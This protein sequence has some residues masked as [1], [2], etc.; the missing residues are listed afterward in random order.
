MIT[1]PRAPRVVSGDRITSTQLAGLADAFNARL[2]S[3]LGDGHWRI[4]FY[5][6]SLFRQIR[7]PDASGFLWAPNAEFFEIY[8]ML[9]ETV[10]NWPVTGPGDPEGI[11]VS[12][13][14]GGYV[15]GNDTAGFFDEPGRLNIPLTIGGH[16]PTTDAEW[17]ALGKAQRGAWDPLTGAVASPSFTAARSYYVFRTSRFS[18]HGNAYGG[19][20]AQPE[21]GAA[22][23]DPDASDEYAAPINRQL[24]FTSLRGL[25]PKTFSTCVPGPDVVPADAY[26]DHVAAVGYTPWA[27]YVVKN[28]GSVEILSTLDWVEGPYTGQPHLTKSPGDHVARVFN[29]FASDFRGVD[30]NTA[31]TSG[32]LHS[33]WNRRAFDV[34]RFLRSQ[35]VLAPA[36]GSESGDTVDEVY[37]TLTNASTHTVQESCVVAGAIAA[38]TPYTSEFT[39]SLLSDGVAVATW[40]FSDS[41][42]QQKWF[43]T[44]CAA[45]ARLTV[46]ST[47]PVTIECAELMAY[48]PAIYDLFLVLRIGGVRL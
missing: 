24:L 33:G 6:L 30:Q 3:G 40:T 5:L 1:F 44:P 14:A 31:A 2:R 25:A 48:R 16:A 8:Q 20:Q 37:P 12:S 27:Y 11:N 39:A 35:Y 47:Q 18:P 23:Q 46:S 29:K 41:T 28:D 34:Q 42:P 32:T 9:E 38:P 13:I 43:A 17:W 45:G 36:R 22:C 21:A 26:D 10:A 19:F 4:H 7:N 15:F